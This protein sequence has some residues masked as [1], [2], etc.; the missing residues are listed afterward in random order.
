MTHLLSMPTH[1][2]PV[3]PCV[4]EDSHKLDSYI[5]A[6]QIG[7]TLS[8]LVL[9]AYG[10]ATLAVQ[11]HP[12]FQSWGGLQ[13]SAAQFTSAVVVLVFLTVLQMVLGELVP[14]SLALRRSQGLAFGF[15]TLWIYLKSAAFRFGWYR[16]PPAFP[17][18]A[19]KRH[20]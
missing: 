12:W 16:T 17:A 18:R 3:V 14:K 13:K 9:G 5:A 6:S 19:G 10:Q 11:L 4:L 20:D 2:L 7:I 8:S 15:R 1:P